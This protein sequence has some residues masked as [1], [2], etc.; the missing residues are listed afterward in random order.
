[1]SGGHKICVLIW[2]TSVK[3]KIREI[4]V[5]VMSFNLYIPKFYHNIS[6]VIYILVLPEKCVLL[7]IK[8]ESKIMSRYSVEKNIILKA[9]K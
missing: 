2:L 4:S 3:A 8:F 5:F 1:M 7:G 6:K 9:Q